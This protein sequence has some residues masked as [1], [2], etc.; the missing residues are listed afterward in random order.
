MAHD[1]VARHSG[2][3][4]KLI[5][6]LLLLVSRLRKVNHLQSSHSR[7]RIMVLWAT[8]VNI[9]VD[10]LFLLSYIVCR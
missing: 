4:R 3:A 2:R 1:E 5:G 9:Y 6:N 8:G 7:F 10:V